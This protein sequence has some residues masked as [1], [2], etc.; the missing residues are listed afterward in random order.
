MKD[1]NTKK[2]LGYGFV[3]YMRYEGAREAIQ[4]KNG[5]GIGHKRIKVSYARPPS[6]EIRN[7]KLYITNLPKEYSDKEVVSLFSQ[8]GEIIEC[9]V[10]KDRN[11]KANRGVAFVQFN[12]RSQAN[13]ALVLN[14]FRPPGS[15]RNLVVK[16]AEDQHRK[17]ERRFMQSGGP[18]ADNGMDMMGQ[19]QQDAYYTSMRSNGMHIQMGQVMQPIGNNM[20]IQDQGLN[21]STGNSAQGLNGMQ[22]H[23]QMRGSSGGM[24]AQISPAHSSMSSMSTQLGYS[25]VM[26]G[27]NGMNGM[28]AYDTVQQNNMVGLQQNVLTSTLGTSMGYS[29]QTISPTVANTFPADMYGTVQV[30]ATRAVQQTPL[31]MSPPHYSMNVNMDTLM[32]QEIVP[33]QPTTRSNGQIMY[34]ASRNQSRSYPRHKEMENGHIG[35]K[36]TVENSTPKSQIAPFRAPTE[37]T[38]DRDASQE[39]EA[40]VKLPTGKENTPESSE[41]TGG[42]TLVI[43]NLPCHADVALLHDLIAPYGRI[44][45]A[46]IEMVGKE[47]SDGKKK[48]DS[49]CTGKGHVQI[50]G[51]TAAQNATEA[52]NETALSEG[53]TPL[54]VCI[55]YKGMAGLTPYVDDVIPT[56]AESDTRIAR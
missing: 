18:M 16:Y 9:R 11:M 49:K 12:L 30:H 52:L 22:K 54:A 43:S 2:S 36:A 50:A 40:T 24:I 37:A 35:S 53:S 17:P 10:L 6:E 27:M 38:R 15:D 31:Q 33:L 20:Y 7:C 5:L 46:Q 3:K 21:Y 44:L 41:Q 39:R 19:M 51:L 23:H 28:I 34:Y 47:R 55:K 14:G 29:T 13:T 48:S 26:N 45:S 42:V 25:T 32:P 4:A 8:F 1:K 56:R